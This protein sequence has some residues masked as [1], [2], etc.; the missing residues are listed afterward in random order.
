[1][2]NNFW[3]KAYSQLFGY[4][5]TTTKVYKSTGTDW[6]SIE[7]TTNERFLNGEITI[8]SKEQLEQLHFALGQLLNH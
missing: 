7:I 3:N 8:K 1:M 2:D 6:V 5:C 4:S